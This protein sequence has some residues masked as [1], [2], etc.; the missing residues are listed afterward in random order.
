MITINSKTAMIM[1]VL[2]SGVVQAAPATVLDVT[3]SSANVITAKAQPSLEQRLAR[4]EAILKARTQAQIETQQRLDQLSNELLNLQGS[5]EQNNLE[6]Q[7]MTVR[8]RDIMNDIERIRVSLTTRP[9]VSA[10]AVVATDSVI[11]SAQQPQNI[12]GRDAYNHA[13]KLIKNER[14]YDEAIPAL[15][16]F[17]RSYPQS[18]LTANAHYWL[19]LLLRKDN[20]NDAAKVEFEK[21]VTQYPDSNKRADSLQK[22]GQLAKLAGDHSEAKRYFNQVLKDYPNDAV[23]KLAKQELAELK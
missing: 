22:L 20:Q 11:S 12:T 5:I 16:N 8:Q 2:Y 21:I 13:I 9:T 18:E 14:K 3:A 4:V 10:P 23:A 6:Q 15:Q 19:G 1:A 7:Q 17:I